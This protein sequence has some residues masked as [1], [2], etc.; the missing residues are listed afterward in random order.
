MKKST[1]IRIIAGLVVS[2]GTI[3]AI[4][5]LWNRT[6]AVRAQGPATQP[7]LATLQESVVGP[8]GRQAQGMKLTT[9]LRA[10]GST[11]EIIHVNA[12]AEGRLRLAS[13][14]SVDYER[15]SQLKSSMQFS[16]AESKQKMDSRLDPASGCLR[17]IAGYADAGS[18]PAGREKL[19]GEDV[20]KIVQDSK[21]V[22]MTVWR[23]PALGCLELRRIAQFKDAT[24]A[25]K[26]S[27]ELVLTS[28][29][30]QDPP[31]DLFAVPEFT[32]VAPSEFF[33]K[34]GYMPGRNPQ[35]DLGMKQRD[36]AY[37]AHRP[38][39]K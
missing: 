29:A 5:L 7:F 12:T 16:A 19:S 28:L 20:Y 10:D 30:R 22:T 13:G 1:P 38:A 2:G 4:A 23:A 9:A 27:S 14:L 15:Q 18:V 35:M 21:T 36:E 3:L 37:N 6:P 39:A 34:R 8:A 17:T 33:G 31:A 32:E 26:D 11:V 25:V 24:G